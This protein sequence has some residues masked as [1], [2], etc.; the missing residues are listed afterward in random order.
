MKNVD[1]P[2]TLRVSDRA[3]RKA[4][5]S[6]LKLEIIGQFGE[7]KALSVADLAERMGRPA[8][9]LYYHINQLTKVGLL[10][11]VGT[12]LKGK[13]DETLF[14][15]AA[16]RFEIVAEHEDDLN[17]SVETFAIA[18][19]MAIRDMQAAIVDGTARISGTDRNFMAARLHY[20]VDRATLKKLNKHLDA[21]FELVSESN[22][23]T[24]GEFC[25]L[26]LALLPLKGR[27]DRGKS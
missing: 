21:I 14:L 11:A 5:A 8:T 2:T 23:K 19:R 15:P 1:V 20:R 17:Q 3:Q 16:E 12:R 9:A 24:A 22:P 25:S 26:T 27:Q 13:R 7:L 10:N 6:P 4:L 18:Q